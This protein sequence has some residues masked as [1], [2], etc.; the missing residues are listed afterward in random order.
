MFYSIQQI[1]KQTA[2]T[3]DQTA[4]THCAYVSQGPLLLTVS[5][6]LVRQTAPILRCSSRVFSTNQYN[7]Q[8]SIVLKTNSR[9]S[10]IRPSLFVCVSGPLFYSSMYFIV[11]NNSNWLMRSLIGPVLSAYAP[12]S[13]FPVEGSISMCLNVRKCPLCV[14]SEDSP[15]LRI[16]L[17]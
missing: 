3:T 16:L 5:N 9:C 1:C 11:S 2:K 7:F 8:D 14:R 17:V 15:S 6:D 10:L 4:C 12:K 13:P